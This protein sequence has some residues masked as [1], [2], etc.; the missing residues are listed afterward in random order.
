M[1]FGSTRQPP[2]P[3]AEISVLLRNIHACFFL[4]GALG[5]VYQVLW[6]RK[7]LLV[8]GSTVHAVSTVLTVF[9]SGLALGSWLLGRL[10]DRNPGAGLRWYGM[11][12]AAVG[13]YAFITLPLFGL[14]QQVYVPIYRASDYSPQVLVATTFVCS[15]AVLLLPALLLGATF[16]V[17]SRF[18]VRSSESRGVGISNL[19]AI[20]TAGA[21][22]GTLAIYFIG[23]PILGLSRSLL[24]AGVLNLGL[25]ALCLAFDRHL[26]SLGFTISSTGESPES[27]PAAAAESSPGLRAVFV[28]FGLSGFAAMAYEVAW[29]RALSLVLG[30][31]I[32]AFCLMLAAFLGGIALGS[33]MARG[34]LRQ[35]RATLRQ[36]LVL[37]VALGAYGMASVALF[38]QMPDWFVSLWPLVRGSFI[39][40]AAVQA[41][42]CVIVMC[43]PTLIM[44]ML[45]PLV[46]DLVTARWASL[47]RRVGAVYAVN[48]FGGILGSFATG[49]LLIPWFGVPGAMVFAGGANLIA[50]GV[51]WAGDGRPGAGRRFAA[52]FAGAAAAVVV[53][54]TV[55]LPTWKPEVLSAGVFLNPDGYARGRVQ[56]ALRGTELLYYRDGLNTT[57]SVHRALGKTFLKV[58]GKTDASNNID[59]STQVLAA[60][61][62]LLLHGS[63]KQVLVIGLG[64]GVSLGNAGRYPVQVLHCAEIEPAVIEGA[65]FFRRENY[66][67]H[68]DPRVRIFA[69]DGRN[70]LLASPLAYDAIISEPSNPWMAGIGYLFTRQFYQLA[71]RR[72][73]PGGIMCQ[74]LQLYNMFPADVKLVL[75]TFR[76]EFPYV[77]VWASLPG[78]LLLLGSMEPY[79]VPYETLAERMRAP[80]IRDA[81]SVIKMDDPNILLELFRL[82]AGA[83]D[84]LT[85]DISWLHEDDVPWLEFNAPKALYSTGLFAQNETGLSR[86]RVTPDALVP[87]RP[88]VEGAA[89]Q[90]KLAQ[91]LTFRQEFVDARNA[92]E[93]AVRLDPSSQEAWL[94]LARAYYAERRSVPTDEALARAEAL[95]AS[96][97]A[98]QLRGRLRF[99]QQDYEGAWAYLRAGALAQRPDGPYAAEL[100][101]ALMKLGRHAEAAEAFRSALSQGRDDARTLAGYGDTLNALQQWDDLL[102]VA[103]LGRARW[104]AQPGWHIMQGR[105]LFGL[106]RLADAGHAWLHAVTLAPRQGEAYYW[107]ARLAQQH[108]QPAVAR[109]MARRSLMYNPYDPDAAALLQ[110]LL[111]ETP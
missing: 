102:A 49:F 24:C 34:Q 42:L 72:L 98:A 23:L 89:F 108:G 93:R 87:G 32:Y 78:D 2:T 105:A 58:G 64:S 59:M 54:G 66:A 40:I 60:H 22:T 21:M 27:S 46:S 3:A 96:P 19:Y 45:F 39:G 43:L 35:A 77:T 76:S 71:K 111:M 70:F 104:P 94:E 88:V 61:L 75:K 8:F 99:E 56:D 36:F 73:A 82:D 30:S 95:G 52:A 38:A 62:P 31:S 67:V 65:R 14:V 5:L 92:L 57:V 13:A 51:L 68:E 10:I 18:M 103:E 50:A 25:G 80:A 12:E 84:R 90:V 101:Q 97:Q 86:F 81:L 69:A 9:F 79:Q 44:G 17:L 28:A 11:L 1:T 109:R 53:A 63:A 26:A 4:S 100:G 83:I 29:T 107:L 37:E 74:W 33:W 6:L 48:T 7:L 41:A 16:P 106:G 47:G 91:A 55:I 110:S 15:A 20:N 85:A